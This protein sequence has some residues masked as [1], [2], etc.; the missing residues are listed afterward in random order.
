MQLQRTNEEFTSGIV[1]VPQNTPARLLFI[2]DKGSNTQNDIEAFLNKKNISYQIKLKKNVVIETL[3]DLSFAEQIEIFKEFPIMRKN[4]LLKRHTG[5]AYLFFELDD[6]C[7]D[8][9]VKV[10]QTYSK[11]ELPVFYHRTMRG[12]HFFS[13]KPMDKAKWQQALTEIKYL[14]T[15]CPHITLRIIPNKWIGEKEIWQTANIS[16][17]TIHRDTIAFKEAVLTQN[18][19]YLRRKYLMVHYRQN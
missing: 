13:V 12:W 14:N 18:F 15:A 10:L 3:Y 9:L 2:L 5:F 4:K 6:E 1:N 17:Q 8:N 16:M 11:Y 7:H 19:E